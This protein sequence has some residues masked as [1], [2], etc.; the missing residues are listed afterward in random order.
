[1]SQ[2]IADPSPAADPTPAAQTRDALISVRD[3]SKRY[4]MGQVDVHALR[5][6]TIDILRGEFLMIV[7]PSG[8]GKSTL[9]NIIG[10]M[11]TPTD[12]TVLF[13]GKDMSRATD[14][15]LTEYRRKEIGFVFQFFNLIPTLTALE[16]VQVACELSDDPM[17]A[18]DALAAVDLSDRADHFPSQLS[19]GQQQ[20]VANARALAGNP[21]LILC[22][23][24]TGALDTDASM[25]LLELL[26]DLKNRLSKTIV[27]ITHNTALTHAADRIAT[28]H[29]GA[30]AS[31][32]SPARDRL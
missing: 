28:I 18:D 5:H 8:S 21:R 25:H 2:S 27:F 16:N 19:G 4:R 26:T 9:L 13:Q 29:D 6:A 31:I 22:D 11:D 20:R 30:I 17:G 7:G 3:V 32:V 15:E 12:G 14:K 24:P 10:G 1:M 23:E